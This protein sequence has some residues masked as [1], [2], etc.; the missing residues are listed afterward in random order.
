MITRKDYEQ[1]IEL[2]K[3]TREYFA[4]YVT[5]EIRVAVVNQLGDKIRES[6]GLSFPN[7]SF[8]EWAR[9]S[10]PYNPHE[11]EVRSENRTIGTLIQVAK[12]AARQI[13]EARER[14]L[15]EQQRKAE[16][17]TLKES[18]IDGR[19]LAYTNQTE[20][21]VQIGRG[22]GSYKT[23]ERHIGNLVGAVIAYRGLNVHSGY[24]K[25]LLMPSA[26]PHPVI[27]REI[28]A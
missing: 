7:I 26:A 5:T 10:F 23:K 1:S 15:E 14:I 17:I 4:Q 22:K 24:K 21:L 6:P 19:R 18:V 2:C 28:S 8:A 13:F 25:R 16:P 12:E 20:F 27:A 9:V 3:E 11:F